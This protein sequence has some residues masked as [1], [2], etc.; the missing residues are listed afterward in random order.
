MKKRSF[1]KG[2][3]NGVGGKLNPGESV[4]E[5][6]VRETKEEIGV[7]PKNITKVAELDFAFPE[8][9]KDWNQTAHVYFCDEW[10]GEPT[11]SEEMSPQWF[12]VDEVPFHAMWPDDI[13]WYPRVLQ[14]EIIKGNF[15]FGDNDDVLEHTLKTIESF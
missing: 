3:W 12:H 4:E 5:A 9:K 14:G 6:V 2:R 11:E 13:F 1:G 15:V 8:H 10:E 7:H